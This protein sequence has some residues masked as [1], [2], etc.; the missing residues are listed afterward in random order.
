MGRTGSRLPQRGKSV[1]P[2][3]EHRPQANTG[4]Q[5]P[6]RKAGAHSAA[7]AAQSDSI[8]PPSARERRYLLAGMRNRVILGV[9]GEFL[10]QR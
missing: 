1:H 7:A 10:K 2:S 5:R 3:G 8:A 4:S 6:H 9:R